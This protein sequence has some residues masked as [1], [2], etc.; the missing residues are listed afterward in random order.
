MQV[1]QLG[2]RLGAEP[3]KLIEGCTLRFGSLGATVFRVSGLEPSKV[4][5]WAPPAWAH[6]PS[7]KLWLDVRSNSVSNPYLAHLDEGSDIDERLPLRDKALTFG[8]SAQLVDVVV[9]DD[10]VSRQHAAVVHSS[11]GE[12]FVVDMDSASG[13]YVNEKRV[14]AGAPTKLNDGDAISLGTFR[15]T[16]TF[17]VQPAEVK[18]AGKRKR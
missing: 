16:W 15:T 1:P 13:T 6:A 7:R 17:R 14:A 4:V 9:R 5:Q 8:R 18:P 3:M 2:E 11:E 12:S 10:S